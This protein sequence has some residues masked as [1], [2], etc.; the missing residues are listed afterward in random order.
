M[1]DLICNGSVSADAVRKS[2][3]PGSGG[4]A[5]RGLV[6]AGMLTLFALPGSHVGATEVM[7]GAVIV[8]DVK[9]Y[10]DPETFDSTRYLPPPPEGLLADDDMDLVLRWQERRTPE[11]AEASLAD[12]EQSVFRWADVLGPEWKE[13]NFPIAKQFFH[14]VYKTESN[15]NKQGKEKWNRARPGALND[16]VEAVSEFKNYG[17]YPS[18]HAAFSHFTAIVLAQ[19]IPEKGEEIM[20][21]G[22]DLGFSRVI[23]GVHFP[24]DVEAGRILGAI[25]AV[26]VRD[27][28]AF[29]ADF[30]EARAEVRKGLRLPL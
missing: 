4:R 10:I 6:T 20:Q 22:R 12:S 14:Q 9:V 2:R 28:P 23:G 1:S 16:A 30:A 29:L 18:G 19:M 13:E 24:S 27:N 17:A 11:M 15:L 3:S 8:K 21:R 25:C 26:M 7:D 5:L